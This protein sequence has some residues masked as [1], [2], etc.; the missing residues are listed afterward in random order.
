MKRFAIAVLAVFIAAAVAMPAQAQDNQ[1]FPEPFG[2]LYLS[3]VEGSYVDYIQ[4]ISGTFN[5]YLI[6]DIDFADLGAEGQNLTNG[7]GAWEAS[8]VLPA[9]P[10]LFVLSEDYTA[11]ID[12]GDKAGNVR[13]FIVGTGTA[14]SVG[15]P[16]TLV[17]FNAL[18]SSTSLNGIATITPT[19]PA[20][21]AN[22]VVWREFVALNGCTLNGSPEKCVFRFASRGDLRMSWTID[23]DAE[24][25]GAVKSRF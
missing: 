1:L 18:S 21:Y 7:I 14:V 10:A 11:A 23:N 20:S 22:E 13:E 25:F 12:V 15:G 8:V 5:F 4:E 9:D 6:A 19:T 16:T 17:T 2:D 3:A 24:S